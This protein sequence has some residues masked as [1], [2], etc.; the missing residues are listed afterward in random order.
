MMTTPKQRDA[1]S[2]WSCFYSAACF[3]VSIL[4]IRCTAPT[5][6]LLNSEHTEVDRLCGIINAL[7]QNISQ[8]DLAITQLK[9][10]CVID[11]TRHWS[12]PSRVKQWMC[13]THK[14]TLLLSSSVLSPLM[15]QSKDEK[16]RLLVK[17]T[18]R[19]E[20]ASKRLEDEETR[21]S[22]AAYI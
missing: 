11:E 2:S 9:R 8:K 17:V 22:S 5:A 20:L 21:M 6:N 12:P 18:K 15:P 7:Q 1:A 14:K 4:S 3:F 16:E 10:V 19:L 13:Q